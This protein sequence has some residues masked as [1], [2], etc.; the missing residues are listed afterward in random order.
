MKV[1]ILLGLL[2][3]LVCSCSTSKVVNSNDLIGGFHAKTGDMYAKGGGLIKGTSTTYYLE[4]ST[5]N[6][7]YFEMRGSGYSPQCTGKWEQ[8]GNIL[9]LKCDEEKDF[10]VLLST[11]YMNQREHTIKI[12]SK[13]KLKY[14][15][16][17]LRRK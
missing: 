10:L 13:D 7:F 6:I 16:I 14:G 12:Q 2:T 4:L 3:G 9:Y 11:A 5:D 17:V 8:K 15:K 1:N